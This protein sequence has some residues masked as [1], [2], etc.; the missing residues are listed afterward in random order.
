MKRFLL[1][2]LAFILIF[3]FVG[4]S[5]QKQN[6]NVD[7]ELTYEEIIKNYLKEKYDLQIDEF[8]TSGFVKE[9]DYEKNTTTDKDTKIYV[10][11]FLENEIQYF[12]AL[13]TEFNDANHCY[14][15][16]QFK[17][18]EGLLC[19]QLGLIYSNNDYNAFFTL[20]TNNL[21]NI[22][23]ELPDMLHRKIENVADI[24]LDKDEPM[25]VDAVFLVYGAKNIQQINDDYKDFVNAFNSLAVLNVSDNN[26]LFEKINP[27]LTEISA[28]KDKIADYLLMGDIYGENIGYHKGNATPVQYIEKEEI[29][30]EQPTN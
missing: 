12:C 29:V 3:S 23:P 26:L 27:D 25:T 1:F 15:N 22:S 18:I 20:Q 6:E 17:E 11:S 24:V 16:Y 28:K 9:Y 13:D 8:Y 5:N 14:D 21:K 19:S 4:C 2:L 30:I 10:T 7:T